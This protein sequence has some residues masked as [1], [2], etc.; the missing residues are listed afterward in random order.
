MAKASK[1]KKEGGKKKKTGGKKGKKVKIPNPYDKP[2]KPVWDGMYAF[3]GK[4]GEAAKESFM[5]RAAEIRE[6]LKFE[7]EHTF[8]CF[9]ARQVDIEKHDIYI[10]LPKT[11]TLARLQI[12]ISNLQ[13][14]GSVLPSDIAVY[15]QTSQVRVNESQEERREESQNKAPNLEKE[16]FDYFLDANKPLA[17]YFPSVTNYAGGMR[18][19]VYD[20]SLHGKVVPPAAGPI[21]DA[22]S[23]GSLMTNLKTRLGLKAGGSKG[24]LT[25]V[26]TLLL[27]ER[28]VSRSAI[29]GVGSKESMESIDSSPS[30]RAKGKKKKSPKK[31]RKAI[32]LDSIPVS[33]EAEFMPP[34]PINIYYDI[35][36]YITPSGA[37]TN[38][39]HSLSV[40][41]P[42]ASSNNLSSYN[43]PSSATKV[44]KN[45]PLLL[46]EPSNAL[47]LYGLKVYSQQRP[48]TAPALPIFSKGE[49]TPRLTRS[50]GP[51]RTGFDIL[52]EKIMR[53]IQISNS[54]TAY[55][56]S[57][58]DTLP[59]HEGSWDR[60]WMTSWKDMG[61]EYEWNQMIKSATPNEDNDDSQWESEEESDAGEEDDWNW[62]MRD[63]SPRLETLQKRI[64]MKKR[65]EDV[66]I[67]DPKD[68]KKGKK[69][70]KDGRVA[71]KK[72]AGKKK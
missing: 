26:T 30:S 64:A 50:A 57:V 28:V 51:C 20:P 42:K 47:K 12:E 22:K 13:H 59:T 41:G 46:L 63:W 54:S 70:K 10:T 3:D 44:D 60:R 19:F 4:T 23:D 53:P 49:V 8:V 21:K 24:S 6:K 66:I 15:K 31:K 16:A 25:S 9:R 17:Y 33:N 34:T 71:G 11:A 18:P 72:N 68:K 2:N 5:M 52:K 48:K 7:K 39:S 1:N 55:S 35:L 65:I 61:A 43:R 56:K 32:V 36:S 45:C 62:R 67:D 58:P 69:G 37:C 27:A 38:L 40:I 29:S 14:L